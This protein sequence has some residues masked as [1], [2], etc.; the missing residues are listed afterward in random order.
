ML[1]TLLSQVKEYKE[2]ASSEL[3]PNCNAVDSVV[4]R[5]SAGKGL[6]M[7]DL[8]MLPKYL[9]FD[10]KNNNPV[11]HSYGLQFARIVESLENAMV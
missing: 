10:P 3:C 11:E 8:K 5:L 6:C 4:N 2:M 1:K 7:A 9:V